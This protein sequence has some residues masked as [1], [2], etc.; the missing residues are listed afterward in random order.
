MKSKSSLSLLFISVLVTTLLVPVIA[1]AQP[2]AFNKEDLIRYTPL[3]EGER[4]PDGRPKVPDEILERMKHVSIEEAWGTL[5]GH[6]FTEQFAGDFEHL[7]PDQI[8]V[9][10]ALTAVFMPVRPDMNKV[11]NEDGEKLGYPGGQNKWGVD[12]LTKGDVYV[13]NTYGKIVDGPTVGDN[14]ATA[15]Y[16]NSGNGI[17]FE[18]AVRDI[19]G[20]KRIPGFTAFV[21]DFHPSSHKKMMIMGV[22]SPILIGAVTVM[23]GDV[24]LGGREGVIFIPPHLA[25]EVVDRSETTRLHDQFTQENLLKHVYPVSVIYG[26]W[27]KEVERHYVRWLKENKGKLSQ[28]DKAFD[29]EIE[30]YEKRLKED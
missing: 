12:I 13:Q 15:I 26:G 23:P 16:A 17:V 5:N 20:M 9:G 22:N 8:L 14:I 28:T 24:V 27:T 1:G 4:F 7:Y 18:G 30:R 6:G 10:R 29:S 2:G 25:Q 11:V 21:R 3:W 19:D